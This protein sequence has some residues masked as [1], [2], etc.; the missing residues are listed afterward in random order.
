MLSSEIVKLYQVHELKRSTLLVVEWFDSLICLDI[1]YSYTY[2]HNLN[3]DYH[4]SKKSF[5]VGPNDYNYDI[6]MP[7]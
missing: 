4:W 6:M 5:E 3:L 1:G 2:L 7:W